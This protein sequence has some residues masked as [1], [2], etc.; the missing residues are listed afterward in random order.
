VGLLQIT[1]IVALM[2][3]LN[4]AGVFH[5]VASQ[6]VTLPLDSVDHHTRASVAD[7]HN[8]IQIVKHQKTWIL[9]WIPQ[10]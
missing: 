5:R 1:I 8:L 7:I 9:R 3:R 6:A 2:L 10:V 4:R